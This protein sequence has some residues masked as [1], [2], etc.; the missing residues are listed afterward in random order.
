MDSRGPESAEEMASWDE[1][2]LSKV[3]P[4]VKERVHQ[5]LSCGVVYSSDFS[6]MGCPK[7]SLRVL[8]GS[9]GEGL[10]KPD[11]EFINARSCD[12]DALPLK[13]LSELS[14]VTDGQACVFGDVSDRLASEGQGHAA[15]L[16]PSR[17]TPLEAA[18]VN[19][20]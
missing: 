2:I 4:H 3:Q 18:L 20:S 8:L 19:N 16:A 13:V 6:G 10:G 7:E 15:H 1:H 12:W 9:V 11:I 5:L 17:T 14:W